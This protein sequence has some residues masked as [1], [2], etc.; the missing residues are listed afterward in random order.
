[1]SNNEN[2]IAILLSTAYLPSISYLKAI[3][4]SEAVHIEQYENYLKQSYRNRCKIYAANGLMSLSIPVILASNKKILIKDVKIDNSVAWQKQHFKS[5]ESAY[6]TSPYYDYL[7][8]DFIPFYSKEYKFLLDYNLNLLNVIFDIIQ[9]DKQ[10]QLTEDYIHSPKVTNDLRN[11]FSPKK[12]IPGINELKPY[13]QVFDHKFGFHPDLSCIDLI[14]N[15]G[16]EAYSYLI[17]K[18]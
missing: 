16:S 15:L 14:F 4:N 1:M 7:I 18:Y 2:N 9:M 12:E 5:I 3:A 17:E 10:I 6:R 8:D 11:F 13:S